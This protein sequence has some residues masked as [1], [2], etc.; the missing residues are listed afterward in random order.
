M[1]TTTFF[2]ENGGIFS[3]PINGSQSEVPLWSVVGSQPPPYNNHYLQSKLIPV[4][5]RISA[6]RNLDHSAVAKESQVLAIKDTTDH[7]TVFPGN[8]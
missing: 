2:K 3:D 4:A 7:F 1:H 6:G 8:I 5:L